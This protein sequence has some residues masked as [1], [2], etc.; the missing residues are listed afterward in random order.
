L[1]KKTFAI[2][3]AMIM[4]SFSYSSIAAD[5]KLTRSHNTFT[6]GLNLDSAQRVKFEAI[7]AH[8][9][10]SLKSIG[11]NSVSNNAIS[12]KNESE[13]SDDKAVKQYLNE[14]GK[15]RTQARYYRSQYSF[16]AN[17]ELTTHQKGKLINII[18]KYDL[19]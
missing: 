10:K 4:L 9:E 1:M 16:E 14:V 19:Y 8:T 12:K 6:Q 13:Q 3:F 2:F 5:P 17:Q 7:K 18:K 11:V 15:A